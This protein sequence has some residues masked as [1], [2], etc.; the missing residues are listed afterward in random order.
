MLTSICCQ[1]CWKMCLLCG[2]KD[3]LIFAASS[4]FLRRLHLGL[5]G[6]MFPGTAG[7][8]EGRSTLP[9]V[10]L[11]S[12]MTSSSGRTPLLT[13]ARPQHVMQTFKATR[14]HALMVSESGLTLV[15]ICCTQQCRDHSERNKRRACQIYWAPC[16][17]S[18]RP[19]MKNLA[20]CCLFT[21]V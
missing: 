11:R 7:F 2:S 5:L 3:H 15:N 21:Y 1:Q 16:H 10:L 8:P 20:W 13:S 6:F 9:D 19:N 14:G 18:F 17:P 12:A 4:Q